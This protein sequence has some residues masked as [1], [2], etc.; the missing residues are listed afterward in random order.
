M[1]ARSEAAAGREEPV[2]LAALAAD[3]ITDLQA[4]ASEAEVTIRTELEPAWTN[5]EPR[6]L[7]RMIANLIDNGIRHNE[8]R[9]H[10]DVRTTA[11]DAHV[12]VVVANGGA[13]IDPA[14]AQSLLEP[15][16]PRPGIRWL[17]ARALDRAV[18]RRRASRHDGSG[19]PRAAVWS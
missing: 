17:R 3:C 2:D 11:S 15:F 19:G 6:L 13:V 7:E 10:L 12:R 14:L 18:G 5:G 4:R 16:R 8:P 9:G 1:L